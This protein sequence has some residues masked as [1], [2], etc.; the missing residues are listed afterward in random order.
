M[1]VIGSSLITLLKLSKYECGLWVCLMFDE[2]GKL[3]HKL[4]HKLKPTPQTFNLKIHLALRAPA[5]L[6][7]FF[8]MSS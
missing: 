1:T 5:C 4:K 8:C 2:V 7:F 3:I 6:S